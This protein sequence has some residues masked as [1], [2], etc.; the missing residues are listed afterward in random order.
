MWPVIDNVLKY[1][2]VLSFSLRN[3]FVLISISSIC[4]IMILINYVDVIRGGVGTR[5]KAMVN[6]QN[7]SGSS[8][9]LRIIFA[10]LR[11]VF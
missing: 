11:K 2:I 8:P 9:S 1:V 3:V 4:V 5:V 6:N 10:P 7:I